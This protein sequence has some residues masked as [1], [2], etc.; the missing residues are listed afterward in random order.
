MKTPS[1]ETNAGSLSGG[2]QQKVLFARSLVRKP[3]V[4][5]ADEPTRGVDVGAKSEI[6]GVIRSIADEGLAVVVISS[7]LPELLALSDRI[8]VM[9]D[10]ELVAEL[11]GDA[12]SEEEIIRHATGTVDTAAVALVAREGQVEQSI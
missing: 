11:Q 5:L 9:R 8:L 12:A 3:T 6:H 4:M 7:E 2:N 1:P 10:G